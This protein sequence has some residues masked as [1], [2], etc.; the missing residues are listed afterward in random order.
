V[1]VLARCKQRRHNGANL[2]TYLPTAAT[3]RTTRAAT[4]CRH[5]STTGPLARFGSTSWRLT[6]DAVALIRLLRDGCSLVLNWCLLAAINGTEQRGHS[7]SRR[8]PANMVA[9]MFLPTCDLPSHVTPPLSALARRLA[10][11]K[12]GKGDRRRYAASL[13]NACRHGRRA[14]N[15]GRFS[16]WRTATSASA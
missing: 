9:P 15:A 11:R 3:P 2:H 16:A 8:T 6:N 14:R 12:H 13:V 10:W 1:T 5:Y 4:A 7:S